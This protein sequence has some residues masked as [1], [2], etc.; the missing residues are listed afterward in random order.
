MGKDNRLISKNGKKSINP[1]YVDNLELI[2]E[3]VK[4]SITALN[5]FLNEVDRPEEKIALLAACLKGIKRHVK[6]TENGII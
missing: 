2:I 1:E 4:G 3:K 6:G 5:I